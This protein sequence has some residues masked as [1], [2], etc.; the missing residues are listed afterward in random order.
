MVERVSVLE[1]KP[2]PKKTPAV[3]KQK[4]TTKL[5]IPKVPKPRKQVNVEK[6][7]IDCSRMN[8]ICCPRKTTLL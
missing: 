7:Y 5:S 4:R 8:K 2:K 3:P 1:S 6:S